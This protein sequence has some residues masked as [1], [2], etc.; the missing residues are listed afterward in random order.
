MNDK[1]RLDKCLSLNFGLSRKQAGNL[2]RRGEVA[3]AGTVVRD[4]AFK[5]SGADAV[6]CLGRELEVVTAA[7]RRY[8]ALNKPKGRVCAN[9]DPLSPTV[10]AL[11]KDEAGGLFCV[12]RLDKDAEGLLFVTDDGAWAH[13]VSS[14]RA[15]HEKTYEVT[16]ARDCDPGAAALF[17]A[18][19]RLKGERDP[20]RPA[21]LE[22]LEPRRA[23]LTVTEGRYHQ[24]KR[25]F[26]SAGNKVT[27]LKRIAVGGVKLGDLGPGEY[28]ELTPEEVALF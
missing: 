13:R 3:V 16:L 25:M 17:A 27:E 22:I 21:R 9:D 18:G 28:R 26:A 11:F 7:R 10:L 19:V 4:A 1:I 14:P 15:G 5:V 20:T 6:T 8:F 23:L 12:G 24:V 2:I